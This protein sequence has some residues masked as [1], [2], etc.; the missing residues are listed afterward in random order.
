[1][2]KNRRP[3]SSPPNRPPVPTLAIARHAFLTASLRPT[4]WVVAVLFLLVAGGLFW[5]GFFSAAGAELS[6]RA[7]FERAPL[8]FAFFV[9]A[10]TMSTL[11]EERR[12]RTLELQR[13][14]PITMGQL[15][16]GTFLGTWAAVLALASTTFAYPLLLS[17]IGPVDWGPVWGGYVGLAWLT[18]AY[19]ALGLAVASATRDIVIANLGA[20][21]LCFLLTAAGDV[22]PYLGGGAQQVLEALS[23]SG[24]FARA[25]RGVLD[26]RDALFYLGLVAAGLLVAGVGL[27]AGWRRVSSRALASRLALGLA[28]IV[29]VNAL[30]TPLRGR[31]DLTEDRRHTLSPVTADLLRAAEGDV[32][33]YLVLSDPLPAHFAGFDQRLEDTLRDLRAAH[34][35]SVEWRRLD[36]GGSAEDAERTEAFGVRPVVLPD[37]GD[38][39]FTLREV[40]ASLVVVVQR[41]NGEDAVRVIGPLTPDQNLEYEV[42]RTLHA[43]IV[44]DTPPRLALTVGDGSFVETLIAELSSVAPAEVEDAERWAATRLLDAINAQVFD[45]RVAL[46]TLALDA[47]DDA[48]VPDGVEGVIMLGTSAE[49]SDPAV[50]ALVAFVEGG[51]GLAYFANPWRAGEPGTLEENI[52]GLEPA[53]ASWGVVVQRDALLDREAMQLSIRWPILPGP[54]GRPREV[55]TVEPDPRLPLLTTLDTGSPLVAGLP[56]VA[57]PPLD[58][59]RPLPIG[60]LALTD[61]AVARGEDGSVRVVAATNPTAVRRTSLA[62][63]SRE[64][65]EQA[66][67]DETPGTYAAIVSVSEIGAGGG[68]VVV[69]SSAG[70][71]GHLFVQSDPLRNPA[72]WPVADPAAAAALQ[73]QV[74][75]YGETSIALF[76]NIGDW[77]SADDALVRI[78]ARRALPVVRAVRLE[79]RERLRFQATAIG[80]VPLV[81]ALLGGWVALLRR[82]SRRQLAARFGAKA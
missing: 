56:F 66:L 63:L 19:V 16:V 22:A 47:L 44:D 79:R 15:T 39:A 23:T 28:A 7:F 73:R 8:L 50:R 77:L 14:F 74:A 70:V 38:D 10:L 68:R 48:G 61:A 45:G 27:E 55:A 35:R 71:V 80:G 3:S 67:A 59:R 49:L 34:P 9:P 82:R 1:M 51:G 12:M 52:T 81:V 76:E 30:A 36:P 21:V 6:L 20:F 46:E 57:S 65:S 32:R 13:T 5:L 58:R 17:S 4:A 72:N 43:L 33:F 26:L 31:I 25:A 78:R 75:Q 42:G 2:R 11:S 60:S 41:P 40:Y 69:A 64:G 37:R 18:A 29:A 54:D 62:Q 24:R 53:L